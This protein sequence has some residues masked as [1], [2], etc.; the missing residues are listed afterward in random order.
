ML[1]RC[2]RVLPGKA[3]GLFSWAQGRVVPTALPLAVIVRQ[4]PLPVAGLPASPQLALL[5]TRCLVSLGWKNKA[6]SVSVP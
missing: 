1:S 2:P 5:H 4:P 3:G 6:G